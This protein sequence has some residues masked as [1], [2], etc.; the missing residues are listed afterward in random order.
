MFA[1]IEARA[2]TEFHGMYIR[3][4]TVTCDNGMVF[5]ETLHCKNKEELEIVDHER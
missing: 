1:R 3:C 4:I 2:I 5:S